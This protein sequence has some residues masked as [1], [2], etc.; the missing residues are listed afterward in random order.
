MSPQKVKEL[1]EI[2]K[3]G[4]YLYDCL[5]LILTRMLCI[6]AR[7]RADCQEVH[8][9]LVEYHSRCRRDVGYLSAELASLTETSPPSYLG[10]AETS[11]MQSGPSASL[12]DKDDSDTIYTKTSISNAIVGNYIALFADD[13]SRR[14]KVDGLD[15]AVIAK[16]ADVLRQ[17]LKAFALKLGY[18][19]PSQDHRDAM[20]FIHR[21]RG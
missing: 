4:Y 5:E 7:E 11:Q 18:D 21:H 3:P 17:L 20:V 6:D 8:S 12:F 13:L 10:A 16:G 14:V 2:T 9:L 1:Q 15:E 19:P